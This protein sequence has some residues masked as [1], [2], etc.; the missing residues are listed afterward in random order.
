MAC[1]VIYATSYSTHWACLTGS[2]LSERKTAAAASHSPD[3]GGLA[4]SFIHIRSRS[5]SEL[6]VVVH[7]QDRSVTVDRHA[8]YTMAFHQF[9][10]LDPLEFCFD[11]SP[12]LA[13]LGCADYGKTIR[14]AIIRFDLDLLIGERGFDTAALCG[15]PPDGTMDIW[16]DLQ[17]S[18]QC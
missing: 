17:R 6:W 11:F 15:F 4:R 16:T 1:P 14:C 3:G 8:I 10:P 18:M 13:L 9:V 12:L 5:D 2:C 7:N